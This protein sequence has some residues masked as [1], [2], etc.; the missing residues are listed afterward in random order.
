MIVPVKRNIKRGRRARGFYIK[1][2][3]AF[4][5]YGA[6]QRENPHSYALI[7]PPPPP[8]RRNAWRCMDGCCTFCCLT[9]LPRIAYSWMCEWSEKYLVAAKN[10]LILY[11]SSPQ[12]GQNWFWPRQSKTNMFELLFCSSFLRE[13]KEVME[14]WII[15]SSTWSR[16]CRAG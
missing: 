15:C 13:V 5:F 1:W 12:S 8:H 7:H 11:F 6:Q 3:D 2:K 14:G 16:W 4:T 10:D 9:E